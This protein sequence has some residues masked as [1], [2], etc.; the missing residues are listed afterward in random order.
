MTWVI[1]AWGDRG[2]NRSTAPCYLNDW[3]I[4][5]WAEVAEPTWTSQQH[6][7]F[8]FD[9]RNRAAQMCM[10]EAVG[11]EAEHVKPVRLVRR[12]TS[13]KTEEKP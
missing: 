6:L 5:T 3:K 1:K 12:T 4:D 11:S 8:R 2:E 9:D 10:T 13:A 7:A